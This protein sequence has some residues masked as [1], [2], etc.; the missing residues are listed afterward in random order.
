MKRF[1]KIA[2]L[3]AFIVFLMGAA[4]A[5][6]AVK[7][8]V[9]ISLDALAAR[10]LPFIAG[11]PNLGRLISQGATVQSVVSVYPSITYPAHATIV[12][13]VTPD[14]HG[15]TANYPLQVGNSNPAYYFY[16][17][18]IKAR[19][20][21]QAAADK[22]IRT[23]CILWPT[24][25]RAE[26]D[27]LIPEIWPTRPG[28]SQMMLILAN[29][30]PITALVLNARYGHML[31]GFDTSRIDDFITAST[32]YMLKTKRPGLTMLHLSDLDTVKHAHG[33]DAPEVQACLAQE[34][35]RI[36]QILTA[37]DDAGIA[38]STV[39][40]ITGDHGQS[41]TSWVINLNSVFA[42]NGL[43][44]LSPDGNV[45]SWKAALNS[46]GGSAHV[47]VSDES[48]RDR[49]AVIL[50]EL[51]AD[52]E[53]TGIESVRE[54]TKCDGPAFVLEA[55]PGYYFSDS[56]TGNLVAP[57]QC[58]AYHGYLPEKSDM[59]T[60]LVAAGPRIQAGTSVREARLI[61]IAPT[62]A[63]ILGLSLPGA[64]GRI[65]DE[66]VVR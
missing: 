49:V 45:R 62:I 40:I 66:I 29:A 13:G 30:S 28:E 56:L 63:W 48:A 9:L 65:L 3:A 52:G 38:G 8:V 32:A 24:T 26:I 41:N 39:V 33:V 60:L 55:R 11:L 18:D 4:E 35:L 61:D 44:A 27:Y 59:H 37:I 7:H 50:D 53:A 46:C 25:S 42:R 6:V 31:D 36:G 22:H 47:Y 15:I 1:A 2:I 16:A 12:T 23:A 34:D 5:T 57:A 17:R 10:D 21:Y 64:L 54:C 58:R 51:A 14:V 43:I 19:T 20:I